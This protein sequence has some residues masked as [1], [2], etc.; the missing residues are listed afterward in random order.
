MKKKETRKTTGKR[1]IPL[2][3]KILSILS[4]IGA[5]SAI[6]IGIMFIIL[7]NVF[8]GNVLEEVRQGY[9]ASLEYQQALQQ[10]PLMTQQSLDLLLW[11]ID[12]M[13]IMGVFFIILGVVSFFIARGLWKLQNWAR[14]TEAVLCAFGLIIV[15]I[16]LISGNFLSIFSLAINGLIFWYLIFNKNV[17]KAFNVK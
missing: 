12:K 5:V 11:M 15:L 13:A 8:S 7:G 2:G 3:I 6:L 9:T 10:D 17:L 1:E 14:I 16:S 4:Y